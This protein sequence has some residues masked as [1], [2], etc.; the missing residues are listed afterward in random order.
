MNAIDKNGETNLNYSHNI[1]IR[2]LQY[3]WRSTKQH[4]NIGREMQILAKNIELN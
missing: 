2:K 3:R 4:L 1:A